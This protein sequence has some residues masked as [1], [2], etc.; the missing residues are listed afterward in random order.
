MAKVRKCLEDNYNFKIAV[1]LLVRTNL[2]L[3]TTADRDA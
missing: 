1:Q 2:R 3:T